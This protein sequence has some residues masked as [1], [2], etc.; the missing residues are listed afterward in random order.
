MAGRYSYFISLIVALFPWSDMFRDEWWQLWIRILQK[1][2]STV[3]QLWSSF[4]KQLKDPF[5]ILRDNPSFFMFGFFLRNLPH[6]RCT[7]IFLANST[8]CDP[9]PCPL[10]RFSWS[11]ATLA[12]G[13]LKSRQWTKDGSNLSRLRSRSFDHIRSENF[14]EKALEIL[15][16]LNRNH[17]PSPHSGQPSTRDGFLPSLVHFA[18][19]ALLVCGRANEGYSHGG[20]G[21]LQQKTSRF[22]IL[23]SL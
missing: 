14:L 5:L 22:Q 21:W 9:M 6:V 17:T 2:K 3:V 7:P 1:S 8:I 10:A 12:R 15:R 13:G 4:G 23:H 20:G 16:G 11:A 19:W 18:R